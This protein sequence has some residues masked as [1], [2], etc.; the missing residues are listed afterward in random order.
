MTT[1][2]LEIERKFLVRDQSWCVPGQGVL[3]RQGYL[4]RDPKRPVRIRIAGDQ[5]FLTIKGPLTRLT[6]AEYEYPIP[7]DDAHII[8]ELAEG[9]IIEKLR[10]RVPHA[11]KV[12]E[13]DE[14]LGDNSG[15]VVAEVE[16]ESEDEEIVL[17]AW[18]GREVSREPRY[19]N[20][21]LLSHPYKLWS[22]QEKE[23]T[24][25]K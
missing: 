12:W 6:R 25:E 14:F 5:G 22:A 24:I 20:L 3:Y 4:S 1:G 15:L 13:I 19:G 11:G 21:S 16:L 10:Y 23:Q 18:V 9:P 7:A 17:P 2:K 8:M